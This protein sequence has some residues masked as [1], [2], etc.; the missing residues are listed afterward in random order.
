MTMPFATIRCGEAK[1]RHLI[2][3]HGW[4]L[5][6]QDGAVYHLSAT[7]EAWASFKECDHA[8]EA[9]Q[10]DEDAERAPEGDADEAAEPEPP[11]RAAR[12]RRGAGRG[13]RG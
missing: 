6:A 5:V 8:E 13:R 1:A 7:A 4:A 3:A 2:D 12:A 11:A 9:E 10:R